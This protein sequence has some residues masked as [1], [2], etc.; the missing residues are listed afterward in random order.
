MRFIHITLYQPLLN[1]HKADSI[2][3]R[4]KLAT[5][6]NNLQT[7][8]HRFSASTG[9]PSHSRAPPAA[10]ALRAGSL[11]LRP[12][13]DSA[14]TAIASSL[15][16]QICHIDRSTIPADLSKKNMET[17][18]SGWDCLCTYRGLCRARGRDHIDSCLQ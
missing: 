10:P 16:A 12:G 3:Y 13:P 17:K 11:Q 15:H 7:F 1:Y 14:G 6:S 9:G 5:T 8:S 2:I 18:R 4:T